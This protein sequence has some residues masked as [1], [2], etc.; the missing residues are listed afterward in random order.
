MSIQVFYFA[1]LKDSLGQGSAVFTG[2]TPVSTAAVW[3]A[4]NADTPLADNVLIA[5]NMQYADRDSMVQDGDE[6]AFFP[7]VTGG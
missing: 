2:A 6:L 5:I 1:S 3:Q 7:P 4:L